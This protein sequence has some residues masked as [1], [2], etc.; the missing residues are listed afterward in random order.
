[1]RL[2]VDPFVLVLVLAMELECGHSFEHEHDH[3][4]SFDLRLSLWQPTEAV[5]ASG[6]TECPKPRQSNDLLSQSPKDGH[7]PTQAGKAHSTAKLL[8]PPRFGE[9]YAG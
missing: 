4:L 8:S 3:E 6:G 2:T 5:T 1:M 9:Y 7:S